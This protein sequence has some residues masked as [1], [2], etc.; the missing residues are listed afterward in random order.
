MV[1]KSM[2]IIIGY[3]QILVNHIELIYDSTLVQDS[4]C[5]IVPIFSYV[6]FGLYISLFSGT[7]DWLEGGLNMM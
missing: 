2:D 1:P 7:T 5:S 4:T 6:I 3:F